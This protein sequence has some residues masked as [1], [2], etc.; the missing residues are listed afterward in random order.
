MAYHCAS[1]ENRVRQAPS[2]PAAELH[3]ALG[4]GQS[5]PRDS[6]TEQPMAKLEARVLAESARPEVGDRLYH[7]ARGTCA[8]VDAV[9]GSPSHPGAGLF[10]FLSVYS[11]PRHLRPVSGISRPQAMVKVPM[12]QFLEEA[13]GPDV[14][15]VRDV[16]SDMLA[17]VLD[18]GQVH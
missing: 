9:G 6:L 16:P 17:Q 12:R 14:E 10:V 8:V 1:V 5:A 11:C 7:L 4:G 18:Q 3:G 13:R 2:R 15:V